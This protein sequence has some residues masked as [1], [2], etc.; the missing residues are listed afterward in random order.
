MCWVEFETGLQKKE[1]YLWYTGASYHVHVGKSIPW[2]V[3][4][5]LFMREGIQYKY[6]LQFSIVT[7]T[8]LGYSL[9]YFCLST[10][11]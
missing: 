5:C 11:R 7:G 10:G 8:V 9:L 4:S 1:S 3:I 2:D 6:Q